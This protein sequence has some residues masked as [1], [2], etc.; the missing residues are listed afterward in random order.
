[1]A[2]S[3]F[4][5]HASRLRRVP[6][7]R[8]HVVRAAPIADLTITGTTV[9]DGADATADVTLESVAGGISVA[10]AV[11]APWDGVCRRC[12]AAT[13]GT[14]RVPVREL[15]TV[16]GDGDETYP[17]HGDDVD[18]EPLTRDAVL[19]ALPLS[20]L[21][22]P[23]CKGLC[24]SCGADWNDG[25]CSCEPAPDPRWAALDI[26]RGSEGGSEVDPLA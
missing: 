3:P 9:P 25:P 15:Y 12:L 2:G 1:V 16:G 4:V 18:L 23:D 5:V 10:G 11:E 7:T 26:L 8:W 21:C 22:R 20:P 6:G 24:P 13:S 14:V 17:L 19:L